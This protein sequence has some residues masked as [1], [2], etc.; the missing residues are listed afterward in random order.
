MNFISMPN[1]NDIFFK[2]LLKEQ[3]LIECP[4]LHARVSA[5]Q[6]SVWQGKFCETIRSESTAVNDVRCF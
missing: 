5:I 6:D 2:L 1:M 4:E 3:W